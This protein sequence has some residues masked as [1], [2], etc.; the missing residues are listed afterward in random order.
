MTDEAYENR[1]KYILCRDLKEEKKET[2][3]DSEVDKVTRYNEET[4][5]VKNAGMM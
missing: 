4:Q 1:W 3:S 2:S 5:E